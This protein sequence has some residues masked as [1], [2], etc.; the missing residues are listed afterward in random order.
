MSLKL[1]IHAR[2]V[3]AVGP[4]CSAPVFLSRK[5]AEMSWVR[6]RAFIMQIAPYLYPCAIFTVM[7]PVLKAVRLG[8][9]APVV[10]SRKTA[11]MSWVRVCA[12]V[13][14]MAVFYVLAMCTLMHIVLRAV[15]PLHLGPV[16]LAFLRWVWQPAQILLNIHCAQLRS[17]HF[18]C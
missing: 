3:E 11:E 12:S 18:I 8:R 9:F 7:Q 2:C 4:L 15:G 14:R 17:P 6:V 13:I 1:Y 5:T 16:F 10:L